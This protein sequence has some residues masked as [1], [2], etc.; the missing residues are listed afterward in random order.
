MIKNK[1]FVLIGFVVVSLL[2]STFTP[3]YASA[4]SLTLAELFE[5]SVKTDM[6]TTDKEVTNYAGHWCYMTCGN[7]RVISGG[8]GT[9]KNASANCTQECAYYCSGSG[10]CAAVEAV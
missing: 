10:G 5:L 9:P 2:S 4:S 3:L 1:V 7:G 6:C 8:G